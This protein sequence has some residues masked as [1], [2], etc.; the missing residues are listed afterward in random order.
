MNLI[1]RVLLLLALAPVSVLAQGRAAPLEVDRIIAIVNNEVI[2]LVELK[3]RVAQADYQLR[4]QNIQLPPPEILERQ[5]LERMIVDK[6]QLQF[7]KE[8]SLNVDDAQLERALARIAENNRMS[9]PEFRAA[10]ERDGVAWNKFR[11]EIQNE[12]LI[13]RLRER[14][15]DNRVTV[16]EGEIEN[17]L[18]NPERA[19]ASGEL[20]I[21]HILI[22][23]PEQAT[24]ERL[25]Q[26]QAK[27]DRARA[28]LQRGADFGQ[29]AA[30]YSDAPDALN[31]GSLG[32]RP[33]DRLPA[34]FAEA[35]EKM[36]PGEIS[37][38]LRSPAGLH[39][40]KLTDRR[41]GAG[42]GQQVQQTRARHILI[43]VSDAVSEAEARRKL[44]GLRERIVNGADFGELARLNSNDLS[45][46]KNGELGWVYPGDTVPEFERAMDGLKPGE[47]SQPVQTPFGWHLIQVLERRIADVS[48]ERQRLRARQALRERKAEEAYQEWLRQ[49][50]DRAYVELRLDQR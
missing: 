50:R 42:M 27:A 48:A 25:A 35:A 46:A 45:A 7:A 32:W 12:I 8:T 20:L 2:T 15:V 16:S 22:R 30:A 49:L 40:M 9:L 26:L 29:V 28:E 18:A 41:G 47:V 31:G 43:K 37:S 24:P 14:E 44:E 38:V 39:I 11:E 34:L 5:I 21:S 4:Q 23:V 1:W 10:L 33:L 3:A 17:Y 19:A 13:A 6:V 36:K